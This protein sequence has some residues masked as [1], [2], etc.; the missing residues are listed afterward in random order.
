MVMNVFVHFIAIIFF[1]LFL[2]NFCQNLGDNQTENLGKS[3]YLRLVN[4]GFTRFSTVFAIHFVN[5]K[6]KVNKIF[7]LNFFNTEGRFN[8][9]NYRGKSFP[10]IL[11]VVSKLYFPPATLDFFPVF[12]SL[13]GGIA[14]CILVFLHCIKVV[15]HDLYAL[16]QTNCP[17]IP[18]WRN[19]HLPEQF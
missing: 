11:A 19:L 10:T 18:F 8:R 16:A 9:P 14:K 1:M 15:L 7:V 12:K 3:I 17:F 6:P 2:G 5:V 13:F 4:L